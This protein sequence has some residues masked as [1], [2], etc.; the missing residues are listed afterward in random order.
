MKLNDHEIHVKV[1][2]AKLRTFLRLLIILAQTALTAG[3]AQRDIDTCKR[4][5]TKELSH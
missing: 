2:K 1:H 4:D 5:N 3:L